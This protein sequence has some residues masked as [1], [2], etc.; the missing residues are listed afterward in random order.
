MGFEGQVTVFLWFVRVIVTGNTLFSLLHRESVR[1]HDQKA[2]GNSSIKEW[3][4][5][6]VEPSVDKGPADV[7]LIGEH[8]DRWNPN[9]TAPNQQN[10]AYRCSGCGLWLDAG[11]R[12]QPRRP[13]KVAGPRDMGMEGQIRVN[14]G[15][16]TQG[17]SYGARGNAGRTSEE[18]MN[19]FFEALRRQL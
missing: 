6:P 15:Q 14:F 10:N 19:I 17:D 5:L 3:E 4:L 8:R 18:G 7:G 11:R 9:S 16:G 12:G 1:R 13:W 2:Q